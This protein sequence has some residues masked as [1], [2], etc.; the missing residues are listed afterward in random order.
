LPDKVINFR[1][2]EFDAIHKQR[3]SLDSD[4]DGV[5]DAGDQWDKTCAELKTQNTKPLFSLPGVL[6]KLE[7]YSDGTGV[8]SN[9]NP[10]NGSVNPKNNDN[11]EMNTGD[12]SNYSRLKAAGLTDGQ[13]NSSH[14]IFVHLGQDV[15]GQ[16]QYGFYSPGFGKGD[17]R[18][19]VV[20]VGAD[21]KINSSLGAGWG[22]ASPDQQ[23]V[24]KKAY[25][26]RETLINDKFGGD[27]KNY[28]K[29]EEARSQVDDLLARGD[30]EGEDRKKLAELKNKMD[31]SATG[32]NHTQVTQSAEDL[33]KT[34]KPMLLDIQKKEASGI[35]GESFKADKDDINTK[36]TEATNNINKLDSTDD[37]TNK[38]NSFQDELKGLEHSSD[39]EV[40]AFLAANKYL[41]GVKSNPDKSSLAELEWQSTRLE[42]KLKDSSF[43]KLVS[44]EKNKNVFTPEEFTN[45]YG[46]DMSSV[47]YD[48]KGFFQSD[49]FSSAK[50]NEIKDI[51]DQV[52]NSN[53]ALVKVGDK[54]FVFAN[55]KFTRLNQID[56]ETQNGIYYDPNNKKQV[57]VW[58]DKQKTEMTRPDS[59]TESST[60]FKTIF[61]PED[62][63]IHPNAYSYKDGTWSKLNPEETQKAHN[64]VFSK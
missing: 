19:G 37:F 54:A 18:A 20:T 12:F 38:L 36:L 55:N 13:L 64:K 1:F 23:Q 21:G 27:F 6:D 8:V 32:F 28:S 31:P 29:F 56:P 60:D 5:Y 7:K 49:K 39:P 46:I 24:L 2:N 11:S 61:V 3:K 44:N 57:Y 41:Q 30:I 50:I 45:A 25:E 47:Q 4:S 53:Q 33:L 40:K 43:S 26:A 35:L 15:K 59:G 34:H 22:T 58:N 62:L 51:R 42:N 63:S 48:Q 52:I 9:R 14:N 17:E 16:D 10:F